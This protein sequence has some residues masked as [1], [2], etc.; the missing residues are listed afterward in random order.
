MD[1]GKMDRIKG[2]IVFEAGE[3]IETKV[4]SLTPEQKEELE[5]T[6]AERLEQLR[7]E[8]ITKIRERYEQLIRSRQQQSAGDEIE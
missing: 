7:E 6:A 2:K 3:M 1:K 5:H 8:A 4:Y